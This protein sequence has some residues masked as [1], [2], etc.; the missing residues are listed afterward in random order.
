MHV[1]SGG[2]DAELFAG[3]LPSESYHMDKTAK[4]TDSSST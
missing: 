3:S 1:Q 4:V 2:I